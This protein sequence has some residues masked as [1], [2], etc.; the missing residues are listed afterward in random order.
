MQVRA[1]YEFFFHTDGSLRNIRL[2]MRRSRGS[3]YSQFD[4]LEMIETEDVPDDV[5]REV[6]EKLNTRAD[7]LATECDLDTSRIDG[8]AAGGRTL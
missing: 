7:N 3:R 1:R 6:I 8:D 2:S 5:I 4:K